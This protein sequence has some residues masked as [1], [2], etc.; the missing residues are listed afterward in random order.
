VLLAGVNGRV[1]GAVEELIL[2][3]S[4]R[5]EPGSDP[6]GQPQLHQAAEPLAMLAEARCHRAAVVAAELLGSDRS[7]RRASSPRRA[8]IHFISMLLRMQDRKE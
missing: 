2:E 3:E 7:S 5:V 4:R 6:G 1:V 8:P